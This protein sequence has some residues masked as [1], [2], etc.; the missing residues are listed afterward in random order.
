MSDSH[1]IAYYFLYYCANVGKSPARK[2]GTNIVLC[3]ISQILSIV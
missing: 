3:H 2:I 1:A